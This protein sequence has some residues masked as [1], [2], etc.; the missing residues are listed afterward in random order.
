MV[1]DVGGVFNIGN[2]LRAMLLM[3]SYE[4]ILHL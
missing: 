2:R 3:L 4:S 1:C